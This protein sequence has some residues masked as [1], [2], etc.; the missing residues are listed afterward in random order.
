MQLPQIIEVKGL[1]VLTSKQIAK[2][3]NAKESQIKQNFKN[4]RDHFVEGKHYIS[5][6]GDEL[7]TFKNQVENFD[8]VGNHEVCYEIHD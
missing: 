1:R 3:Y 7:R 6:T 5:F 4:N 2:C 8:L